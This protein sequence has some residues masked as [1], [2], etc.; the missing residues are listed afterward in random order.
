MKKIIIIFSL[1]FLYI[2]NVSAWV[3]PG[4]IQKWTNTIN[5]SCDTSTTSYVTSN[6]CT[7]A[8]SCN[9]WESCDTCGSYST[10][11]WCSWTWCTWTRCNSCYRS[12]WWESYW[13]SSNSYNNYIGKS[14]N[15]TYNWELKLTDDVD[16]CYTYVTWKGSHATI[17]WYTNCSR[18]SCWAWWDWK[19]YNPKHGYC[20]KAVSEKTIISSFNQLWNREYSYNKS[21]TTT[22]NDSENTNLT[23]TCKIEWR[24][25][26]A[27][28]TAPQ[29]SIN[30]N[31]FQNDDTRWCNIKK[32]RWE[33]WTDYIAEAN[34]WCEF[35]KSNNNNIFWQEDL[36]DNLEI[37]IPSDPSGIWSV[38]IQLW[39]C[40][41]TYTPDNSS[42]SNIINSNTLP[43]WV[44]DTYTNSFVIKYKDKVNA[45]WKE[46]LSL[47][48]AF[49]VKR[50]DECLE[51]WKNYLSIIIKDMAVSGADWKNPIPNTWA[52]YTAWTI[53]IDNSNA[54]LDKSWDLNDTSDIW[55]N[56]TL[57]WNIQAWE[58]YAI[59]KKDDCWNLITW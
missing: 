10:P 50:L 58:K 27:D 36:L 11:V 12:S 5:I 59:W 39:T 55:R 17:G 23:A 22:Y 32:Y 51:E 35:Y 2:T 1:I 46:Q 30:L 40:H 26:T 19:W 24:Y 16:N 47:V 54:I 34:P 43:N 3:V 20:D 9:Y 4:T 56:Y 15:I 49:W 33:W 14:Q 57:K 48:D 45:L 13:Q 25:A 8:G 37:T 7:T 6:W 29:A 21:I 31:V 38:E 52:K 18:W 42:L 41:Y 28:N 44:R 53:N